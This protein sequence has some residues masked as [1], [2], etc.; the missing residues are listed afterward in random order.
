MMPTPGYGPFRSLL[1]GSVTAKARKIFRYARIVT[2]RVPPRGV[3]KSVDYQLQKKGVNLY[4]TV[5]INVADRPQALELVVN[6]IAK[7]EIKGY[8]SEPKYKNTER[9]HL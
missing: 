6:Q 3:V 2:G 5:W 7:N 9:E 1:L 8:V 4:E